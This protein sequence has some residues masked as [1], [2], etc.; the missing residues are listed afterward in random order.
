MGKI[1]V[2]SFLLF[3]SLVSS[4]QFFHRK[5]NK[6]DKN[7]LRQGLWISYFDSDKKA[8]AGIERFKDGKEFGVCRYYHPNG[9]LRLKFKF[10]NND[11]KVKYFDEKRKLT[12]KGTAIMENTTKEIHYY[13]V[14]QWKFYGQRHHIKSIA[15]YQKGSLPVIIKGEPQ[16]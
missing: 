5:V 4:A 7:G 13:W 14:G 3:L 9:K 10:R 8:I 11:I 6:F 15:I 1:S 2:F 12:S 16:N